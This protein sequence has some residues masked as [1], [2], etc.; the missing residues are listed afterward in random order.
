MIQNADQSPSGSGGPSALG[1]MRPQPQLWRHSNSLAIEFDT[2]LTS[3]GDPNDNHISIH[4][5]RLQTSTPDEPFPQILSH[6]Y[7]KTAT[8]LARMRMHLER[9]RCTERL[10]K[11]P[12]LTVPADLGNPESGLRSCLG[13][14]Y[15]WNWGRPRTATFLAGPLPS[16][17]RV[18]NDGLDNDGNGLTDGADPS[19]SCRPLRLSL[20]SSSSS[21]LL[22]HG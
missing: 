10:P 13:R 22:G 3:T 11:N 1:S 14:L 9:C 17:T 20:N 12:V 16:V 4:R 8:C 18:C 6:P 19:A 5:R 2:W 21:S 7:M 15:R